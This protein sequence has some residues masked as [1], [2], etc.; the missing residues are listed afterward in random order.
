[1][2]N[3]SI[4]LLESD[5]DAVT[6]D[7]EHRRRILEQLKKAERLQK[8]N[9]ELRKDLKDAAEKIEKLTEELKKLKSMPMMLAS[10]DKTAEAGGVPS[11][12]TFYRRPGHTDRKRGGRKRMNRMYCCHL[13][14][15]RTAVLRSVNLATHI[16]ERSLTYLSCI[17]SFTISW[18]ADAGFTL[19]KSV[20]LLI[21]GD[22]LYIDFIFE[23][24]APGHRTGGTVMGMDSGYIDM[25]VCS[26]GQVAGK[27]M[28]DFIRSFDRREKHTHRQVEQKAF[29][30]LRKLDLSGVKTLVIEGL[31]SVKSRT[32]GMFPRAHNR[33]LS[34]WLYAREAEW[35]EQRCE[36]QGIELR[37]VSPWKTSQF[38]RFCGKW[39][40]RSRSGRVFMCVHCGH[41]D[42]ADMNGA[43]N[44][45]LLGLAGVYSL[46]LLPDE[47][48]GRNICL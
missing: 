23:K 43:Q 44:I 4:K 22:N 45:R 46:R 35:L 37:R 30:E 9:G 28:S 8:E 48:T 21:R 1:M 11:S 3:C 47:F 27:G 2:F 15:A 18:W 40:R 33:R 29:G 39:D 16:R 20:R 24:D 38:C 13:K 26:D 36:E 10:S 41:T 12:R 19:S 7:R 32:R 5:D 31:H 34:H 42:D 6:L 25:A 14:T 17:L